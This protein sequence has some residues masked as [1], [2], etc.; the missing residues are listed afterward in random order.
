[1]REVQ[2]SA[3][4]TDT[5]FDDYQWVRKDLWVEVL[6]MKYNYIY[7]CYYELKKTTIDG[8]LLFKVFVF[9]WFIKFDI[10]IGIENLLTDR[11]SSASYFQ[12][13]QLP[14]TVIYH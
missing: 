3:P 1:M 10:D 9:W 5:E 8:Q 6:C 11:V 2:F 13:S 14:T 7:I 4:F 12:T